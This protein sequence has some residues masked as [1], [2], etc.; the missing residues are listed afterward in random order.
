MADQDVR[1][2]IAGVISGDDLRNHGVGDSVIVDVGGNA[3]ALDLRCELIHP[4]RED[5]EKSAHQID[6]RM[7][8]GSGRRRLGLA[9]GRL[10]KSH[11]RQ[12]REGQRHGYGRGN[13][14]KAIQTRRPR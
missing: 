9:K 2:M 10:R 3:F 12:P 13:D 8:F 6:V 11:Q 4:Q 5:I 7:G 14:S 1:T